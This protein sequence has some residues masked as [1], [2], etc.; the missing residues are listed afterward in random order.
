MN[1]PTS[2]KAVFL[3]IF[4]R[5]EITQLVIESLAQVRPQALY[6]AADGPRSYVAG[7]EERCAAARQVA[8]LIDW[9]GEVHTLMHDRN[10]GCAGNSST[11]I[12]WYLEN[13]PEGVILDDDSAPERFVL[14]VL[15][16]APGILS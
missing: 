10:L 1:Q 16:G 9:P 12:T 11:G 8:T 3:V 14:P 4:N 7:D 5:P 6:I 13:V 15:R 2:A